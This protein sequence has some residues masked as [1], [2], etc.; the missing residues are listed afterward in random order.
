M[1]K[2]NKFSL[3]DFEGASDVANN[4]ID[5]LASGIGWIANRNTP[6]KLLLIHILK[7]LKK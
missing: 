3:F 7:K 1:G 5:K 2:E 6:K 4:L